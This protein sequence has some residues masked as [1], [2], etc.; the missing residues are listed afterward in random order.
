[1]E[2]NITA[3]TS[4]KSPLGWIAFIVVILVLGVASFTAIQNN[5]E[6]NNNQYRNRGI[7]PTIS[8]G[9]P[10]ASN[11][12]V[13]G[14]WTGDRSEITSIDLSSRKS[15]TIASLPI[16]IKKVSVLSPD[17]VIYID[18][19]D[20]RYHGSKITIYDIKNKKEVASI[21]AANGFGIDDYVI[22][23]NKEYIALWE[24]S[25]AEN[26][27][28]LRGGRSQVSTVKL[29]NPTIKNIIYDETADSQIHYPIAI[30][31]NGKL[32]TDKFLPN[33]PSGGAGWSYGLSVASFNGSDKQ[34]VTSAQ[35][36]SFGTQPILSPDGKKFV[37][38]GY[39]GSR[40]PGDTLKSGYRQALLTSNSIETLDTQTL[41]RQKFTNLPNTNFY[42]PLFWSAENEITYSQ[43]SENP[44]GSG[45]FTYNLSTNEIKKIEI[46]ELNNSIFKLLSKLSVN[47]F[48]IATIEDSDS[49]TGDL[50]DKA[51]NLLNKIYLFDN[52]NK[53]LLEL[54]LPTE[55]VQYISTQPANYFPDVLGVAHAQGGGNPGQPNVTVID[56]YSDKPSQENLQ[57]KTFLLK[58]EIAPV[59]EVQQTDPPPDIPE[60]EGSLPRCRDLASQRCTELGRDDNRCLAE[61]RA[62]GLI[63]GKCYDSPLYLYGKAGTK[64]KVTIQTPIFNESPVYNNGY[65]VTLLENGKLNIDGKSY[66]SIKYDYKSNLKRIKP[67]T[68]GIIVSKSEVEKT[69]QY[70]ALNLGLNAK[71]TKDLINRGKSIVKTPYAFIS[72]FDNQTSQSILPITFYPQ[73][74]NYL[75]VVFYF[76]LLNEEPN[77]SPIPP[78]FS[79]PINRD[80]FTAVEISEIVE[81]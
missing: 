2:E 74:D 62:D 43:L 18:Q 28:I 38:A 35:N 66:D 30:L 17:K 33:D 77:Y 78:K 41:T 58:P 61:Q 22:S 70:Y 3:L 26:S 4:K 24:V 31:N 76:K 63:S 21:P 79:T 56:F 72:F 64:V 53:S 51:T 47:K 1:M 15:T 19:T 67:P 45:N 29:S 50:G 10:V 5:P 52:S 37:F 20:R 65:V 11:S 40:G 8:I 32:F 39:D 69:L 48:L 7:Q 42:T 68:Q 59:R 75:N 44:D 81:K 13:L 12:I 73:P 36:G 23:K 25:F 34:D 9:P 27:E 55:L 60:A 80:G 54:Q 71:E 49:A 46:P 14:A 6:N 16:N 57:L